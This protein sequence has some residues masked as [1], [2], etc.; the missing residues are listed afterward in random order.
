MLLVSLAFP[1]RHSHPSAP[2]ATSPALLWPKAAAL[3]TVPHRTQGR[4][5]LG[6]CQ[7]LCT[8]SV[9]QQLPPRSPSGTARSHP[10]PCLPGEGLEGFNGSSAGR[11][12]APAPSDSPSACRILSPPQE[13][14]LG[15][16][17][18]T[19]PTSHNPHPCWASPPRARGSLGALA[20]HTQQP[21]TPRAL[22]TAVHPHRSPE[23]PIA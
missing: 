10:S 2:S 1:V 13:T 4:R 3:G 16:P 23:P 17:A 21:G 9:P 15:S 8:R 5:W 18:H 6:G 22:H 11:D 14:P 20:S 7:A 12:T 19:Y